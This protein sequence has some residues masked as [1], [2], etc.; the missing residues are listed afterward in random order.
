[1]RVVQSTGLP[2]VPRG[3]PS[4]L[5]DRAARGEEGNFSLVPGIID[6]CGDIGKRC[7]SIAEINPETATPL[8]SGG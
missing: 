5:K 3:C 7:K 1:M 6:G 8:V 4:A 2:P